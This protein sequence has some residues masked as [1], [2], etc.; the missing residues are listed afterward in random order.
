MPEAHRD[1]LDQLSQTKIRDFVIGQA[2]S[3]PI[4]QDYNNAVVM[5]TALRD[6]HIQIV[7][8]YIVLQ[9][10]TSLSKRHQTH[11]LNLAVGSTIKASSGTMKLSLHG[12]GGTPLIPFLKK[13]RNETKDVAIFHT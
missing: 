4:I 1:F 6:K 3:H 9:S 11:N 2:P 10:R 7:T 13:T 12:T 5:L 8:R